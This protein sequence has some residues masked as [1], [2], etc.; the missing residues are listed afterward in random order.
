[1][2]ILKAHDNL[3]RVITLGVWIGVSY[4]FIQNIFSYA[5]DPFRLLT[6]NFILVSILIIPYLFSRR[7]FSV[8]DN[9]IIIKRVIGDIKI[10][11]KEIV[12]VK[13]LPTITKIRLR[14]LGSGGLYGYFGYFYIPDLGLVKMYATRLHDLLLVRCRDGMYIISPED[15]YS[16]IKEIYTNLTKK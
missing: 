1:M 2:M 11:L 14:L 4:V 15:T 12:E 5:S 13:Q 7:G 8:T 16:F 10:P 3:A 9:C 6:L